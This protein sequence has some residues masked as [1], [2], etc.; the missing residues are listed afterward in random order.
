MA[1]PSQP[2]GP[3]NSRERTLSS[4]STG[5]F[6]FSS[7]GGLTLGFYCLRNSMTKSVR[8]LSSFPPFGYAQD[9]LQRESSWGLATF[10]SSK[11]LPVPFPRNS[12]RN[13]RLQTQNAHQH[14]MD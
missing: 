8:P 13:S 1:F 7:L 6:F 2:A 11:K 4:I 9:K 12:T 14:A 5:T 3:L 10:S